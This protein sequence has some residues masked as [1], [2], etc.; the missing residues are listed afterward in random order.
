MTGVHVNLNPVLIFEDA[1]LEILVVQIKIKDISIRVINAY[2]PQEY[3]SHEKILCFYSVLDQ[4]IQNAKFDSCLILLQLDANAKVG[5][6]IIKGDPYPQSP[7]GHILMDMIER[8]EWILCNA[9]ENRDGLITRRRVTKT[10][11]E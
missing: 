3:T 1:N 2:G 9:K 10:R 4:V 6:E 7:N 11:K 8:N 5:Y